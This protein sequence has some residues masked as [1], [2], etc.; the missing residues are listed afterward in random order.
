MKPC[1]DPFFYD[2]ECK[3]DEEEEEDDA[4]ECG[5]EYEADGLAGSDEETGDEED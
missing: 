2:Y 1:E 5:S 3:G 4:G